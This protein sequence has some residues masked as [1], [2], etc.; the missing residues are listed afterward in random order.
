L[1]GAFPLGEA[2]HP[3]GRRCLVRRFILVAAVLAGLA[4]MPAAASAQGAP[5][6]RE[7]FT[8][9]FVDEDF[10]GTGVSV[11]V[12]ERV[13]ANIWEGDDTFTVVFRATAA[14]TYGD[15]TVYAHNAG[16]E[17][18]R[19]EGQFPGPRTDLVVVTGVRAMLRIP[20][21]G[22]LTSDHGYLEFLVSFD[23]SG[24]FVG[25][26]VLREAGGHPAFESDV[27][28]DAAIAALGIPTA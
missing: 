5:D 22:V 9:E 26:E 13:V 8:D 21:Q 6:L 17:D 27:F 28:C 23:E 19:A 15:T 24:E 1:T 14:I 12:V 11:Q 3:T 16:R 18:V 7:R 4:V 20:G 2:E 25:L 10:C